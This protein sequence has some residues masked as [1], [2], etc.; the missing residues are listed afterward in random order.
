M[1]FHFLISPYGYTDENYNLKLCG[2]Q[3]QTIMAPGVVGLKEPIERGV[4]VNVLALFHG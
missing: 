2:T 4:D 3:W 1:Y